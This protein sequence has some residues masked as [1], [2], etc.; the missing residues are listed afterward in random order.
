MSK[1]PKFPPYKLAPLDILIPYANNAR[2]HSDAQ[3]AKI[4]ASIVEFGFTNPVLTDGANGIVAGQPF[5]PRA[6]A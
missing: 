4:A 3:V 2:T 1:P 5:T 6:A